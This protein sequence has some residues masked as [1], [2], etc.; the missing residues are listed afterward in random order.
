[1]LDTENSFRALKLLCYGMCFS[2][3]AMALLSLLFYEM[4]LPRDLHCNRP[5]HPLILSFGLAFG[6]L[7]ICKFLFAIGQ[8]FHPKHYEILIICSF[9]F[10]IV[11]YVGCVAIAAL[12]WVWNDASCHDQHL[13]ERFNKFLMLVSIVF[14][15]DLFLIGLL[16]YVKQRIVRAKYQPV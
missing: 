15:V 3:A 8:A 14:A 5:L 11:C 7:S 13:S 6:V 1:M 4:E 16:F 12:G 9:V 2:S 10:M